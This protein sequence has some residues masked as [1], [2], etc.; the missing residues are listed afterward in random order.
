MWHSGAAPHNNFQSRQLDSRLG[1]LQISFLQRHH[2]IYPTLIMIQPVDPQKKLARSLSSDERFVQRQLVQPLIQWMPLGGSSWLFISFWLHQE[3]L[4]VL[5]T[6]PITVVTAVWAAYSK[7]FVDRLSEIYAERGKQ[8]A[9]ALTQWLDGLNQTLKWQLSDFEAKYLKCQQLDCQEDNPD[10][11]KSEDAIFT[12]LL[13]EVFVPL[14]LSADSVMPGYAACPHDLEEYSI[15]LIWDL[16]REVRQQPA[17]RQIAIRA[18]GGYGK[19]TLLK[20]LTYTYS[21]RA[22]RRYQA[23]K[24][25]PFLLYLNR[26]WNEFTQNNPPSLPDLLTDYHLPKLPQAETLAAPPN[27]ALNLLKQGEALVM[28]DGFDEVPP[29]KRPAVSEWL[30]QQMRHYSQSVF[31]VTS[32]PTAYANDYVAKRPTAS[33]WVENFHEDQRRRFVEQ[34]YLCQERYARGGRNT[35]DVQQRAKQ[36]AASLLAQIEARPDLKAIAGNALLLNMMARFHRDKQGATLPHRKVELYQDICELQLSRRPKAKGIPLLLS[37]LNQRQEVLQIVALHMMN[38]A[39]QDTQGFKEIH[40]ENLLALIAGAL[41][42]RDPHVQ[43]QAFL[44]QIVQVNELLVEQ[45][46]GI[47]EFA[48]LSFQEFLAASE[49]VRLKQ[50]NLLYEQFTSDAW[51]PTISFYANLVNPT[52][53]IREAINRHAVDLAYALWREALQRVDLSSTEIL[54]L[55][56]LGPTLQLARHHQLEEYLTTQQWKAADQETYRLMITA[57]NKEEGQGFD[58]EDL[59]NFPCEE[60]QIMDDLWMK[61][62]QGKFGFSVQKQIY[63]ECGGKLNGEYPGDEIWKKFG[64]RVGWRKNDEWLS[65]SNFDPSLTA[66]PGNAP[67]VGFWGLG[68]GLG[69]PIFKMHRGNELYVFGGFS[70]LIQRLVNCSAQQ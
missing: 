24:L 69:S 11:I 18:W 7:N 60:L 67:I 22:Y 31:I 30:S 55:K 1:L 52:P 65:Y 51:K 14:S 32:R 10:G 68:G 3:W 53:L 58:G 36:N 21:S 43:P 26:C 28:F 61:Y 39:T 20:H 63:I 15:M 37:S 16:L 9:D 56:S 8:D 57:V 40:Q 48:H 35:S 27:W 47:Y 49:I 42:D 17:Y 13:H 54:E 19:T 70:S 33:F 45:E 59:L 50:E 62:S 44:D 29:D 4:Q 41:A 64:D 6:F 38:Q 12:P 23:P 25:I 2:C 46:G 34:W 66:L 5:L